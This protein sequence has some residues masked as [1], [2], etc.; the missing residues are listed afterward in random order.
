MPP[1]VNILA[2]PAIKGGFEEPVIGITGFGRPDLQGERR[3]PAT[4]GTNTAAVEIKLSATFDD[5]SVGD[6]L[7]ERT[8]QI[9]DLLAGRPRQLVHHDVGQSEFRHAQRDHPHVAVGLVGVNHGVVADLRRRIGPSVDA[10][11]GPCRGGENFPCLV[12]PDEARRC[13]PPVQRLAAAPYAGGSEPAPWG[14]RS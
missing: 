14:S 10:Q 5:R 11:F 2:G 13:R 8:D 12:I 9:P 7:T 1:S 4:S 3:I 6:R